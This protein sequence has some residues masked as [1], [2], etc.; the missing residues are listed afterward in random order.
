M[1]T[2]GAIGAVLI[3]EAIQVLRLSFHSNLVSHEQVVEI[4]FETE[5]SNKAQLMLEQSL[6]NGFQTKGE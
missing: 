3:F 2:M 1:M 5:C 4:F 6:V